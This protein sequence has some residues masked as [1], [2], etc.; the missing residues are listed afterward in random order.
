MATLTHETLY[1]GQLPSSQTDIY[2]PASGV[3]GCIHNVTLHNTNTTAETIE[4]W[5][6]NGT[7]AFKIFKKVLPADDSFIIDY[8]NEGL[9]VDGAHKIQGKTTTASKVTIDISG[10]KV[11]L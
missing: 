6:H 3:T 8:G 9:V 11:V 10:T 1:L 5:K 4:L 7:T 2:D